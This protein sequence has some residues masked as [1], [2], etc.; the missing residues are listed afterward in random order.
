[1]LA[2]NVKAEMARYGLTMEKV[3]AELCMSTV[4]LSNKTNGKTGWSLH[5]AK[6]LV[7]YFNSLGS[8][9]T[10]EVLFYNK[11]S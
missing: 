2:N 5:E 8:N 11:A 1:M 6:M 9:C 10:I 3:A 7:D 4:S